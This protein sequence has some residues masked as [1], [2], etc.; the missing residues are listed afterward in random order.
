MANAVTRRSVLAVIGVGLG[1]ALAGCDSGEEPTVSTATPG[2][3]QPEDPA[4]LSD[5]EETDA[6]APATA[7]DSAALVLALERTRALAT[8]CQQIR[9]ATGG[10]LKTQQQVQEALDLQARVLTDVL[11][12]GSVALPEPSTAPTGDASAGDG[13]AST[14]APGDQSTSTS[15]QSGATAGPG[16]DGDTATAT[17]PPAERAAADLRALGKA[18]LEDVAPAALT[19]LSEVSAENL[20]M[21][22]S[23]AGQRGATA[24]LLGHQPRWEELSGPT[25]DPAAAV[26]DAYRP[27]VYGFEVLAARASGD[28]RTAYESVLTSLRAVTRQLTQLAGD[29]ASPAP[30][31]YGL[32]GGTAGQE[33]RA[34]LAS[35]L[36]AVLPPTIMGPTA[37]FAGDPASV[38]GAVRLLAESVRLAQPWRPLTGFPGMQVPGA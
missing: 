35:D 10:H 29:A 30:L 28:E 21:L 23:I 22:L 15:D 1:A 37:G 13:A 18:C 17:M 12:A 8:R 20:P 5:P 32:P 36:L 34:A 31:G 33:G 6:P 14:G 4:D 38:A 7:A 11:E 3:E 19:S 2:P 9:G 26:L 25:G 16:G 27:A 24:H